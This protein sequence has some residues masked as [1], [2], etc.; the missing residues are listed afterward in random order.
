MRYCIVDPQKALGVE[1]ENPLFWGEP[2]DQQTEYHL[3]RTIGYQGERIRSLSNPYWGKNAC[4]LVDSTDSMTRLG[5]HFRNLL[6]VEDED[7]RNL[8]FRYYDPRVLRIFLPACTK[9]QLK[10]FFGPVKEYIMEDEDPSRALV[11]SLD[12]QGF[13]K[14]EVIN[15][16]KPQASEPTQP[17]PSKQNQIFE[18]T[19]D[20]N[21]IV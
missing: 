8:Y 20:D 4:I 13:L 11:F 6:V 15:L 17:V 10:E 2:I 21:T 18:P 3:P 7:G 14:K 16:E 5:E 1:K 19:V 12:E 9:E